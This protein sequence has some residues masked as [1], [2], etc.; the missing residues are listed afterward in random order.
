MTDL[1]YNQ[2]R[3]KHNG[4]RI[5]DTVTAMLKDFSTE[6]NC[7]VLSFLNDNRVSIRLPDG[8]VENTLATDCE[9]TNRIEDK[10][11]FFTIHH[12]TDFE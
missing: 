7:V 8:L 11:C 12:T 4:L 2:D 6:E 3:K 5:G 9:V 1:T 10:D